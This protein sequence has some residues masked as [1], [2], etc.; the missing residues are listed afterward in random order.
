MTNDNNNNDN[1]NNNNNNNYIII[2]VLG[3]YLSETR[4]NVML[5]LGKTKADKTLFN[6]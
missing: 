3:G 6:M 4:E 5:L 2:D 1:N